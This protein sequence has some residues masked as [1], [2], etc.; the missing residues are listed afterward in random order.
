MAL[1]SELALEVVG[2]E[3]LHTPGQ[4]ALGSPGRVRVRVTVGVR[5]GECR[6]AAT[7]SAN[8]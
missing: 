6:G 5:I 1:G 2:V 8:A 3:V 7:R 4:R